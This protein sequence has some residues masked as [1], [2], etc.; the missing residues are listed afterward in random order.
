MTLYLLAGAGVAVLAAWG[1]AALRISRA[2]KRAAESKT[3]ETEALGVA[4]VQR[5][6][7]TS[8]TIERDQALDLVARRN[9]E[10]KV[11]E[12]KVAELSAELQRRETGA[13]SLARVGRPR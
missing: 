1:V 7:A 13:E 9:D 6:E 5:A 11:L 10:I 3:A 4:Q 12:R 8:R 2:E